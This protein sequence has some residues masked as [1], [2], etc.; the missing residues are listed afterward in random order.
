MKKNELYQLQPPCKSLHGTLN[1]DYSF[2]DTYANMQKNEA[3]ASEKSIKVSKSLRQ[4][5]TLIMVVGILIIMTTVVSMIF[6]QMVSDV[7]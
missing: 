5:I 4:N 3:L 1:Q 7:F 6:H 2:D